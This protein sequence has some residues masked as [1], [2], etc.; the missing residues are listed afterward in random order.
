MEK[1]YLLRNVAK[2]FLTADGSFSR[3]DDEGVKFDSED[4]AKAKAAELGLTGYD[5]KVLRDK[6]KK[7]D[8]R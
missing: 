7:K 5:V 4:A 3:D 2:R 6:D 8:K 1:H